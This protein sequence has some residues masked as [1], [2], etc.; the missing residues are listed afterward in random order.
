MD[1]M[2]VSPAITAKHGAKC[3]DGTPPAYKIRRA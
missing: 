2:V 1:V 3:L